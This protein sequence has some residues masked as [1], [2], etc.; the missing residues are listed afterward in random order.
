MRTNDGAV[1]PSVLAHVDGLCRTALCCWACRALF[2]TSRGAG[3]GAGDITASGGL[4]RLLRRD[5]WRLVIAR[6]QSRE[7]QEN[8]K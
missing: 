6:E 3:P 7:R 8:R 2:R 5:R 4:R 1:P